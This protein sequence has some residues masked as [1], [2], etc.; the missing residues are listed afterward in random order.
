MMRTVI[1]SL[2]GWQRAVAR[3]RPCWPGPYEWPCCH[4][5]FTAFH[6]RKTNRIFEKFTR[7]VLH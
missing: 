1:F 6:S 2:K 4:A 7:F 3:R 5:F